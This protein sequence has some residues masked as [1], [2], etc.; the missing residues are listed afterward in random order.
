M[1]S[2]ERRK[3]KRFDILFDS[4]INVLNSNKDKTLLEGVI[5]NFSLYGLC[6]MTQEP[7]N[8]GQEIT[9]KDEF[10]VFPQPA[11]VR[12]SQKYKGDYYKA[13]LELMTLEN[14]GV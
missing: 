14:H 1:K 13:G 9:I 7:L 6:I 8:K 4:K 2:T 3:H 11:T 12:W 5:D 10:L